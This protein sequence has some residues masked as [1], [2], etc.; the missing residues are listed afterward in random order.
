MKL[1]VT[2]TDVWAAEIQDQPGGLA[3]VMET[4]ASTGANLECVI[5]RRQPDKPGTGVIFVSPLKGKKSLAAAT[6]A[7]FHQTQ[8]IATVRVEGGDRQGL[9]AQIAQAVGA[10]GVNMRGLS[11]AAIGRKFV[12]YLGFDSWEDAHKAAAAIKALGRKK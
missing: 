6:A 5:A 1:K 9:G 10:A 7:G 3:K 4:I 11:A 2:K 8:Q 12:A